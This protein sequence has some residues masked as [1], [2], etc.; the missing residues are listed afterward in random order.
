[1]KQRK[2]FFFIES[3]FGIWLMQ[4]TIESTLFIPLFLSTE[5]A[6][7]LAQSVANIDCHRSDEELSFRQLCVK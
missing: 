3:V 4:I 6:S 5:G 2:E 7:V 1:M